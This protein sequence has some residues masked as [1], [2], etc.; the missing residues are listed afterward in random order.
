[1]EK[2]GVRT[3]KSNLNLEGRVQYDS[4]VLDYRY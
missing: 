3:N 2:V 1:M 4:P